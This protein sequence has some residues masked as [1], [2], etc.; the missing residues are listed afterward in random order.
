MEN[1]NENNNL[2]E[3]SLKSESKPFG[4]FDA[5]FVI[6][7]LLLMLVVWFWSRIVCS[8]DDE[9]FFYCRIIY[10]TLY[11]A[12]P[13]SIFAGV[14]LL[15]AWI[16]ERT[17]YADKT[18]R[19]IFRFSLVIPLL[20]VILYFSLNDFQRKVY[21]EGMT[22]GSCASGKSSLPWGRS[23]NPNECWV[24]HKKCQNITNDSYLRL[25]NGNNS[26]FL[27]SVSR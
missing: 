14:R 16:K 25:C 18:I 11:I 6:V 27:E 17:F 1:I 23:F 2:V 26:P 9:S 22:L 20:L 7:S 5:F 24:I 3:P 19:R 8:I 13:I 12:L 15:N 4:F 10:P 21:L